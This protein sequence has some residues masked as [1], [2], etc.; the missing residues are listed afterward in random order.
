VCAIHWGPSQESTV[1]HP[2][3][4]QQFTQ[5]HQWV[6][7]RAFER[8]Q[9]VLLCPQ[10]APSTTMGDDLTAV[11]NNTELRWAMRQE[12]AG[13]QRF[14]LETLAHYHLDYQQLNI[15]HIAY[16]EREAAAL[17]AM[18]QADIAPGTRGAATEFG[19]AFMPTAWEAFDLVLNRGIYF[20]HLFQQ[21]LSYGKSMQAQLLSQQ[22]G[23][24]RLGE[25]GKI[26][27]PS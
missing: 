25:L 19:L 11:L 7:V 18:G 27:W 14:L 17:L 4:I 12:G 5:H 9:G 20:R 24:Y 6:I 2:A 21:L 10:A 22:L 1:R 3:L 26:I 15:A 23:G 8:E 16:S 13:S